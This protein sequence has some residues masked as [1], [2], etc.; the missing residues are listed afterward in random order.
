MQQT[1]TPEALARKKID[2]MLK[3]AGWIVVSRKEYSPCISAAAIEEGLLK[4]NLEADYLLFLE[5]KAIGVLE[6]KK[7]S[8]S[9]DDVVA[10]Q[11]ENYTHKLLK[12]YQYWENPLPLIYLSNGK[13]LLFKNVKIPGSTYQK[14]DAM[15]TPK[16]M[17]KLTG[18]NS[19]FAG[20]PTLDCK[21]LRDCQYEAITN[22]EASFR[23]SQRKALI[24]LATGAGKTFTACLAAYRF[25]AYTPARRVLFLVDRNNLGKQAEGAFGDFKLTENGEPFSTIYT[26]ER[27]RS[28][29]IS[30]KTNLVICTIQR[31]FSVITGQELQDDD[32]S[33]SSF[34][35]DTQPDVELNGKLLLPPDFFDLIIV[36]ECHRSIYGRWRKVLEY[37]KEARIIGLTATPGEETMAFFNNNR[38]VNYTLEKSI[39]DGINV[40]HRIYRIRT[41]ATE[42]GDDI[43][44][45]EEYKEVS[46]YTGEQR[47]TYA[48]E[49]TPY[50]AADLD[51]AVINS[52]QI[53]LVL[54]S[55]RNAVYT[56]L[57]PNREKKF[58]YLPKTLIFAKNDAH[59]DNIIKILREK[60]FP[61]QSPEFAQKITYSAGDSNALIKNFRHDKKFRIAVTV[62]L[63]ATGTDVKPLE[64]VIFMRD[65]NSESLYTQMKG[66]GVRTISDEVLRNVTPNADTK[67]IFYLVDA[68][69]VTE[70][71]ME[72]QPPATIPTEGVNISLEKLL[73]QITHGYL[74]DDN[75]RLLAARLSRIYNKS[76]DS[77]RQEF[78]DL[79]GMDMKEIALNIYKAFEEGTLLADPFKDSNQPNALRKALVQPLAL[80]EKA[81]KYLL[82]LNAG[83][84]KILQ[85]GHDTIIS[86]GFSVENAQETVSKFEEYVQTH[87]DEEK[88]LRIISENKGEPIT[89]T[90]LED[91]K[92]KFLAANSRFSIDN[93]WHSYRILNNEAVSPFNDE[94]EKEMLTNLIQLVRFSL[95]MIP[96]LRS[97][98]SLSAQRF[99]LWCGQN[100]REKLNDKQ[101]EIAIK[102]TNYIVCNG[103]CTKESLRS[104]EGPSFLI[105]AKKI[106]GSIEQVDTI[107]K[108]LSTFMLAA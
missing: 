48:I 62:T 61:G 60:I 7:E 98:A 5:G 8:V 99:E 93:L 33:E 96:K 72:N 17:V 47:T 43:C 86:A 76:T 46:I 63:V 10:N 90:M 53:K 14:L 74:P 13:E 22:L 83:F 84:V 65:V 28:G 73:E 58:E 27:I 87:R 95:K 88:A 85:P 34:E 108:S 79:A 29:K 16:E 68:I 59:A 103:F 91:L 102:I 104:T 67:D 92:R 9:L 51:R 35:S 40:D 64:V 56:E 66:R 44:T 42:N 25:L 6:A 89:Y 23:N 15:H 4:G 20:L 82:V 54:E 106:F 97:L 77:Q 24:V 107:L 78:T 100:Q 55:Y 21:G 3:K 69:G 18:I 39:A 2:D 30:D 41:S 81:R 32:D 94:S 105:T 36:D 12:M 26:T 38:V 75:L 57:Y 1:V 52:E 11:A 19:Y 70:H 71:I 50:S 45:G 37:F 80:N 101:R 49:A 31:L